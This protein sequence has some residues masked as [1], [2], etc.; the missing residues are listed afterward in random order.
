[1]LKP[2]PPFR[3]TA[4]VALVL[5][6]GCTM[7]SRPSRSAS[8]R[9]SRSSSICTMICLCLIS[10][11]VCSVPE[12]MLQRGAEKVLEVMM[13][14]VQQ[15][16]TLSEQHSAVAPELGRQRVVATSSLSLVAATF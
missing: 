5:L 3:D 11:Y 10:L 2:P 12:E 14:P 16:A 7:I 4:V 9:G 1:M 6:H 15:T 8:L 13:F